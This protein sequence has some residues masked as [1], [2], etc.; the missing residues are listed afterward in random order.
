MIISQ[1]KY[2]LIQ[3]PSQTFNII[4]EKVLYIIGDLNESTLT[5]SPTS[6]QTNIVNYDF[7]CLGNMFL[8][9]MD[10]YQNRVNTILGEFLLLKSWGGTPSL[11]PFKSQNF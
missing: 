7:F 4:L 2:N 5:L 11:G 8:S 6:P 10:I 3:F 1:I 9:L